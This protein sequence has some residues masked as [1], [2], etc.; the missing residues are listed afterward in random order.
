METPVLTAIFLISIHL[1]IA[2]ICEIPLPEGLEEC[3]KRVQ[4]ENVDSYV[5]SLYSWHCE[6]LVVGTYNTSDDEFLYERQEYIKQLYE[7]AFGN[8]SR[9]KR[10]IP[11][12]CVRREYRMLSLFERVRFHNAINTLKR[13]TSVR[14]NKYDAIASIHQG[15]NNRIAHG[16]P[17][18][19]GWHRVYLLVYETALRQVDPNI[20]IPYWD[21]TRDNELP[22]PYSSSIWSNEY[23]GTPRGPVIAGPFAG[24]R[25]PNGIQLTRNTGV[26]G[27]L[28]SV[29]NV[30]NI[31]S[32]RRQEEIVVSPGVPF[33]YDL[34]LN[35]GSVHV[36]VGGG[37]NNLNTAAFDPIFFL[38]HAYIDY[39]WE[40]FRA[41]IR[42]LGVNPNTYPQVPTNSFH[43]A[44]YPTGLLGYTQVQAYSDSL[45]SRAMYEP[46]PTCSSTSPACGNRFLVCNRFTTRCLPTS[47]TTR[48]KRSTDAP[49]DT[50]SSAPNYGLPYQNDF[51]CDQKCD[52]SYWAYVPVNIVSMRPPTFNHYDSYP[53]RAGTVDTSHD[54]YQPL[55]YNMT[56]R[57]ISSRQGK[58][59]TYDRCVNDTVSGQ[60]F[61]YSRGINYAGYYKE[62]SLIDQRLPISSSVGFV[63]VRKPSPGAPTKVLIRAHD[64]CGRECFVTCKDPQTQRYRNC[65]GAIAVSTEAPLMFSYSFETAVLSVFD[66]KYN[67]DCPRYLTN[68]FFLTVYC[69]Y[70]NSFQYAE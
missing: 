44:N 3:Y 39:I 37:M 25:L 38:H 17:G 56:N 30:Q 32:R 11:S 18:F 54:I 26:D 46:V 15:T 52:S 14:P 21:S 9:T 42:S 45:A 64:S 50:C 5:G 20:C 36:Y 12:P 51:C 6:H 47:R 16:G 23:M 63:A 19:L 66:F 29:T 28:L 33:L 40:L 60:V 8:S 43:T 27:Q 13:D 34:E 65:S 68:N 1:T 35:H 49:D 57:Y 4:E 2:K 10:Q 69:D 55:A 24:W 31:L 48:G 61:V 22:N 62:S 58:P 41:R 59:M 53:V 67:I 7:E 70:K